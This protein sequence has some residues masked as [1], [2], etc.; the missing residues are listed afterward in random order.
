MTIKIFDIEESKDYFS[1]FLNS[2][3]VFKN[4]NVKIEFQK[5]IENFI[6][7]N[8]PKNILRTLTIGKI[9]S[10]KTLFYTGIVSKYFTNNNGLCVILSGTKKTLQDQTYERIKKDL[11]TCDIPVFNEA[12]NLDESVVDRNVIVVLKNPSG[13]K[14]ILAYLEKNNL[15]N[16]LIIDDESDQA[17]LN[18]KNYYNLINDLE[19]TTPTNEA[20]VSLIYW[21]DSNVK[22]IQITA[23]P[24]SHVLT[25]KLDLLRP[26]LVTSIPEHSNYFGNEILFKNELDLIKVVDGS[27]LNADFCIFLLSYFKNCVQLLNDGKDLKNVSC[28]IHCSHLQ[29][30]NDEIYNNLI[31]TL[32]QL[33]KL[34]INQNQKFDF[35][36]IHSKNCL[37]Y[38]RDH[39]DLFQEIFSKFIIQRVYGKHDNQINWESFFEQ[40]KYFC[41]IGGNKLERG[42]T[43]AGLITTYFTRNSIGL[44][45]SDTFEQRCRFFGNR[46]DL[47]KY[48]NIYCTD[49]LLGMLYEYYENEKNVFQILREHDNFINDVNKLLPAVNFELTNPT[50]KTVIS[51]PAYFSKPYSWSY[52]YFTDEDYYI[53]M[54]LFVSYLNSGI[55]HPASGGSDMNSHRSFFINNELLINLLENKKIIPKS[56]D[57]L[58]LNILKSFIRSH[59]RCNVIALSDLNSRQRTFDRIEGQLRVPNAVHSSTNT[60]GYIGDSNILNNFSDLTIQIGNYNDRE[61][62]KKLFIIAFKLVEQDER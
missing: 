23:T 57:K 56:K 48:I 1:I 38:L 28:F 40:N 7:E 59:E 17:S 24:Q 45:N 22:Y 36:P 6:I 60:G 58:K 9:Q 11:S 44:S 52:L 54:N 3:D 53:C 26:D 46:A 41:L 10:G 25:G 19:E 37:K 20:L 39:L 21:N 4:N 27:D 32:I 30:A 5:N 13:I 18:N 16:L 12:S 42:F 55:V 51:L 29:V 43:I 14:S 8:S 61:S 15:Q 2:H 31:E 49:E 62:D 34:I 50:R 33:E 35:L 47:V